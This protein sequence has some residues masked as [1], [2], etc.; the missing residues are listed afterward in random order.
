[1]LNS[2]IIVTNRKILLVDYKNVYGICRLTS[3]DCVYIYIVIHS[4]R[5]FPSHIC[6]ELTKCIRKFK[7]TCGRF[8]TVKI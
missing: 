8:A 5:I 4:F 6:L 2:I 1:M 3:K 7:R